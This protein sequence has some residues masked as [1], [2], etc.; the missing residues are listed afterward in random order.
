MQPAVAAAPQLQHTCRS[1]RLCRLVLPPPP[2]KHRLPPLDAPWRCAS[3]SS[4]SMPSTRSPQ[5]AS[6][7][8]LMGKSPNS[9]LLAVAA[10]TLLS[11]I[12]SARAARA[13][14]RLALSPPPAAVA[15]R[16]LLPFVSS[17]SVGYPAV[18]AALRRPAAPRARGSG[19]VLSTGAVY[20]TRCGLKRSRIYRWS[21]FKA[22]R[23]SR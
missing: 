19:S 9:S 11:L 6:A 10:A 15:D 7:Y 23:R 5:L 12:S 4:G 18:I 21:V 17:A 13:H 20:A 14:G 8:L 16:P 3:P 22:S 2:V 1:R